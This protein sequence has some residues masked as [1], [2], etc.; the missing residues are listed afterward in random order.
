MIES[1]GSWNVDAVVLLEYCLDLDESDRGRGICRPYRRDWAC[2][3]L[4]RKIMQDVALAVAHWN[5][6]TILQRIAITPSDD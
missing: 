2:M 3:S 6:V 1:G 5:A 4:R